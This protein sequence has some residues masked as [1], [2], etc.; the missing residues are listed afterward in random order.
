MGRSVITEALL[1]VPVQ[2]LLCVQGGCRAQQGSWVRKGQKAWV[3]Q[4]HSS[5]SPMPMCLLPLTRSWMILL[6]T[7]SIWVSDPAHS[8]SSSPRAGPTQNV[9]VAMISCT[10]KSWI[11]LGSTVE[12]DLD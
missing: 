6:K 8:Q 10:L 2:F 12:R 7:I 4:L 11:F 9:W 5:S 1:L 3:P